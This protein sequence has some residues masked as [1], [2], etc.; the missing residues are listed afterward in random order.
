[1]RIQNILSMKMKVLPVTCEIT[2]LN[3]FSS[4]GEV[5]VD[6]FACGLHILNIL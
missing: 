6:K 1:M 3:Y 5:D 4:C 2:S